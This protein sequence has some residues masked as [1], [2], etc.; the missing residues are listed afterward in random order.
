[1]V[2]VDSTEFAFSLT[3]VARALLKPGPAA[4]ER[5]VTAPGRQRKWELLEPNSGYVTEQSNV[6]AKRTIKAGA[7]DLQASRPAAGRPWPA[8]R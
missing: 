4:D 6:L 5:P 2:A 1:M 3:D 8:G 7:M